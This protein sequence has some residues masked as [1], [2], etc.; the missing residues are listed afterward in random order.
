MTR[1]LG[2]PGYRR[3]MD[4]LLVFGPCKVELW[5]HATA[6]DGFVQQRLRLVLRP[7]VTLVCPVTQGLPFLGYRIW[8]HHIRLDAARRQRF[9]AR[10]R[11]LNRSLDRGE[12][13]EHIAAHSANSLIAWAARADTLMM[14][15]ASIRAAIVEEVAEQAR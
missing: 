2:A 15:R 5:R 13:T 7:E 1:G 10:L 8:P 3:Y 11:L 9:Q 4:D 14:R 6:I 12:V